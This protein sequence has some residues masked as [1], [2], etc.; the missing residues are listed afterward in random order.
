MTLTFGK[1]TRTS[2]EDMLRGNVKISSEFI[3]SYPDYSQAKYAIFISVVPHTASV[4]RRRVTGQTTCRDELDS[5]CFTGRIRPKVS[6]RTNF[7]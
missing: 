6:R 3:L 2:D 5:G 7:D 4:E 1:G